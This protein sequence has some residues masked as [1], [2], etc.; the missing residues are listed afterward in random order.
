MHIQIISSSK[1][2]LTVFAGV[3]KGAREVDILHMLP[4]IAPI[5]ANLAT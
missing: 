1:S 2:F 4:K 5:I 3:S